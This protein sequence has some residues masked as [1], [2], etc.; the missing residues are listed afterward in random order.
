MKF[1]SLTPAEETVILKKGTEPPFT[2]K[3]NDFFEQGIYRCKQ[4]SI[5]LFHS[6]D[7]FASHCGWPSFDDAI[8]GAV[9]K[10]QDADGRRMEITCDQCGAHLGHV[11]KGEGLTDK[12]TRYCV[13]SISMDFESK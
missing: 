2:G 8:E 6:N 13:N 11:F 7:K 4:C 1:K 9:K 12:N 5:P 3:F 10:T